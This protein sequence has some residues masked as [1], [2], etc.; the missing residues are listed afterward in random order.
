MRALHAAN[1]GGAGGEHGARPGVYVS[2]KMSSWTDRELT[3]HTALALCPNTTLNSFLSYQTLGDWGV[4]VCVWVRGVCWAT[5]PGH[6]H[7]VRV[8]EFRSRQER[9]ERSRGVFSPVLVTDCIPSRLWSSMNMPRSLKNRFITLKRPAPTE[10]T[11]RQ[12]A[13]P[14]HKKKNP[15]KKNKKKNQG[16][17]GL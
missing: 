8:A 15:N 14:P 6:A 9:Q 1:R 11:T 2:D 12:C 4:W 13:R 17:P 3:R 10:K 5:A 7:G 16:D